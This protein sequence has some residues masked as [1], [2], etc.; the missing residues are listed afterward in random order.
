MRGA[1]GLLAASV[2]LWLAAPGVAHAA[3][4]C[5]LPDAA[6]LWIDFADGTVPFRGVFA[7]PGVIVA[8]TGGPIPTALR[9][10]G[11][12]TIYWEMHLEQYVG[13]AT[14]PLPADSAGAGADILFARAA[15]S[16]LTIPVCSQRALAPMV[17]ASSAIPGVSSA[18]LNTS[19]MSIRSGT[20]SSDGYDRS[21]RISVSRGLTGMT[22]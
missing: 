8:T 10:S 16:S 5:G 2:A 15:A 6:P 4:P 14:A 13:T 19:T 3:Q 20:S 18:R 1:L 17:T 12:Q 11:A 7:K 22:R 9:G 21:P